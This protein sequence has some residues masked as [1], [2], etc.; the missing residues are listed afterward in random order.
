MPGDLTPNPSGSRLDRNDPGVRDAL[1]AEYALGT[2]QGPARHRFERW[3]H[4]DADLR[5]RVERWE[6]QLGSFIEDVS[7]QT[8]P[9]GTWQGILQE[10]EPEGSKEA[11]VRDHPGLWNHLPL[12]RGAAIAATVLLAA[13]L[14]WSLGSSPEPAMPERMAVVN[15]Q[16]DG[17]LWVI[18][19]S[20]D[21]RTVRVRT[22]RNAHMGPDQ[23]CPLWLRAEG[24][25]KPRMVGVLPQEEGIYTLELPRDVSGSLDRSELMVSI[26][27]KADMP[28]DRPRGKLMYRGDW[29]H[30]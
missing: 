23:I 4:R 30:L 2:L 21:S 5:T 8:P 29:I 26:E 19:A 9:S 28:L 17:P 7:P 1:A 3:L 11:P 25:E 18:A 15:S 14:A 6:L 24:A 13:T 10:V 27:A 16:G 22:V 20:R 12:W